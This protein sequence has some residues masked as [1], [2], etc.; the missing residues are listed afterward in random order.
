MSLFLRSYETSMAKFTDAPD[1]FH[2]ICAYAIFGALLTRWKYRCVLQGGVPPRWTNIWALLIGDSGGSRK[3]TCINMAH[4]V[5]R[6]VDESIDAPTEGSPEGLLGWLSKR[7]QLEKN[8]ACG[9]IVSSEFS[10]LLSQAQRTYSVAL[11]PLLMD[12]HDI[13]P[14]KKRQLTKVEY[15]IPQPRIG[16]LG[17]IA[18]DL[19]P[20]LSVSD[21]W[22]GGFFSRCLLIHG[23]RVRKEKRGGT[24]SDEVYAKH[25]DALFHAL[26]RWRESQRKIAEKKNGHS[27]K[28]VMFDY[29]DAALKVVD[30]LPEPPEEP[31]LNGTLVRASVHLHKLAAIEQIDEN[32]EASTIGKKATKRAL[33]YL[34]ESWWKRVP[35]VIDECFARSRSDFEG[36]RLARRIRRYI[37]RHGGSCQ[38]AEVMRGCGIKSDEVRKAITSLEDAG[39]VKLGEGEGGAV[40][41]TSLNVHA[42]ENGDD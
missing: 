18:T 42:A 24:P 2:P 22:L 13:P 40:M 30:L 1:L 29:D 9:I 37:I 7:H 10:L 39:M 17:G 21:D 36:D 19:L 20:S 4:A 34:M 27:S 41:V 3:S 38:W 12:L 32:P 8:N 26:R 5:M 28:R 6:R 25:A 16:M 15:V 14:V 35:E 33:D 23:T 11:K 31:N